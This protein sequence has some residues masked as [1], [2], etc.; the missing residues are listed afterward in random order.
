MRITS[1]LIERSPSFSFKL[2][3]Q[4]VLKVLDLR[5][6]LIPSIENLSFTNNFFDTIDLTDNDINF[7]GNFPVLDRLH[8]LIIC[9]NSI[10]TIDSDLDKCLKNLTYL[11]LANNDISDFNQIKNLYSLKTLKSLI[12]IEN[13][14]F[15]DPNYFKIITTLLPQLSLLDGIKI[16]R[17]KGVNNLVTK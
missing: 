5:G 8:T 11:N 14:I 7:L 15:N 12:L 6:N 4:R 13:P 16:K 17:D 9:N 1:S 3:S 2:S 10:N